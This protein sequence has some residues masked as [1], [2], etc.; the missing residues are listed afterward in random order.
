MDMPWTLAG[1][2]T[3]A[4]IRDRRGRLYELSL[5]VR[6]GMSDEKGWREWEKATR[7]AD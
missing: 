2:L 4:V 3:E 7:P 6:A 1:Q 5:A